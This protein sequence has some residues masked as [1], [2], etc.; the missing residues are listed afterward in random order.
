MPGDFS[1]L[2]PKYNGTNST[3]MKKAA[4]HLLKLVAWAA[5]LTSIV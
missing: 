5:P 4:A 3:P 2:V 1:E